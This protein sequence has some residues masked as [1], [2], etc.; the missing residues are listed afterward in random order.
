MKKALLSLSFLLI[1]YISFAQL[2]C[3][4][5]ITTNDYNQKKRVVAAIYNEAEKIQ[6]GIQFA[7]TN[8]LSV[9]QV[10]DFAGMFRNDEDRL[11]FAQEAY[12]NTFDKD[13][14]Y[15]VYDIFTKFSDAFR[16]YDYVLARRSGITIPVNPNNPTTPPV[17]I[18]PTNPQIEINYPPN[19][20]FPSIAGYNGR[21]NCSNAVSETN[22]NAFMQQIVSSD[23]EFS[24]T[25]Y[26]RRLT[27]RRA[28]GN[29][30][31]IAQAMKMTLQLPTETTRLDVLKSLYP[32]LYDL[33]NISQAVQVLS[34]RENQ[35]DWL[36][37][38]QN[39]TAN[40][41]N[42]TNPNGNPTNPVIVA[43]TVSEQEFSAL[44]TVLNNEYSS[45]SRMIVAKNTCRNFKCFS[46]AQ[47]R[48]LVKMFNTESLK[49]DIAKYL[50]DYADIVQRKQYFSISTE[51]YTSNARTDF[52][53]FLA[54]KK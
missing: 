51:F 12:N 6:K 25:G 29:C 21:K 39:P 16:L 8:C 41:N 40:P 38:I 52:S 19:I 4:R 53:N 18:Q 47:V 44:T 30:F 28:G 49:L 43:C 1:S 27:S 23:S 54:A 10:K 9:V 14:F 36:A 24:K 31:S 26:I 34:T 5:P 48:T 50:Y 33:D 37:F 11:Q 32:Y 15:E 3:L 46:I 42:P 22:F 35:D 2:N 20:Y 17:V 45:A 13:N 7:Q